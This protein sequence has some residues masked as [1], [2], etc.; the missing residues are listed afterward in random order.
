MI[1]SP[2]FFHGKYNCNIFCNFCLTNF[3]LKCQTRTEEHRT[4][5][6]LFLCSHTILQILFKALECFRNLFQLH[7]RENEI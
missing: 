5:L 4:Y 6:A 7:D 1:F 3:S 2:D